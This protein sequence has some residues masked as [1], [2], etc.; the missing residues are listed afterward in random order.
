MSHA[1]LAS[2]TATSAMAQYLARI[3]AFRTSFIANRSGILIALAVAIESLAGCNS[4]SPPPTIVVTASYPDAASQIV[5]DQVAVPIEEQIKDTEGLLSIQ[6]ES[7]RG[8]YKAA[9]RF[10]PKTDPQ[11]A[12]KLVTN[13]LA[14]ADPLLPKEVRAKGVGVQ[15]D[16]PNAAPTQVDIVLVHPPGTS[17]AAMRNW[18]AKAAKKLNEAGMTSESTA[19]DKGRD[20]I[21]SFK[22]N[23]DKCRELGVDPN[24]VKAVE[25]QALQG[26]AEFQKISFP[27]NA[28]ST[29]ALVHVAS[30]EVREFPRFIHR[31]DLQPAV[32]VRVR[33]FPDDSLAICSKKS[34]EILRS[35]QPADCRAADLERP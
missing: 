19:F 4:Y 34:L 10:R 21:T 12:L 8:S 31:V 7:T 20:Q 28:G 13:Q 32:I 25:K 30:R 24:A 6:S 29:V 11:A 2:I 3:F 16:K 23:E 14:L 15:V 9:L 33:P 22:V 18:P 17:L 35:I 5:V 27:T 1:K 26:F